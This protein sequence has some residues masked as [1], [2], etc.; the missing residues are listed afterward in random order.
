MDGLTEPLDV[1]MLVQSEL[2]CGGLITQENRLLWRGT[3]AYL[4]GMNTQLQEII[5]IPLHDE[6][7]VCG[8]IN[9]E[10]TIKGHCGYI[11]AG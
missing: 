8:F 1:M 11:P 9:R 2:H 3:L 4:S 7:R 10:D 6:V 5:A